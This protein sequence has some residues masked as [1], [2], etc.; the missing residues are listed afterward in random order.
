MVALFQAAPVEQ[1]AQTIPQAPAGSSLASALMRQPGSFQAPQS[2]WGQIPLASLAQMMKGQ[3]GQPAP[4][5]DAFTNSALGIQ[6]GVSP[7]PQ[8]TISGD[9]SQGM[10]MPG[11]AGQPSLTSDALPNM[12]GNMSMGNPNGASLFGGTASPPMG[13]P[14][15]TLGPQVGAASPGMPS[16]GTPGQ[17]GVVGSL[18]S[19]LFGGQPGSPYAVSPAA[20]A[21]GAG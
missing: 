15:Q 17:L 21:G 1:P 16:A 18:Y 10:T 19:G 11:Y 20:Y 14:G 6:P 3:G 4:Q 8:P 12:P 13:A 2:T 7:P 5:T 9:G